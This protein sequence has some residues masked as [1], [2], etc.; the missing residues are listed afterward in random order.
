MPL[1]GVFLGQCEVVA[2]QA[3]PPPEARVR[4]CCNTGYPAGRCDRFPSNSPYDVVRFLVTADRGSE[5]TLAYVYEKDH[6]P[7]GQGEIGVSAA[8][9][10]ILEAQAVTYWS[11]YTERKCKANR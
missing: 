3:W 9:T 7:A 2:S 5:G 8:A 1:G 11:S 4:E 6:H 10:E